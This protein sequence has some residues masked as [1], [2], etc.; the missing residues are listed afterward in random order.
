[1]FSHAVLTY[2]FVETPLHAGS[3]RGMGGID[4]PIQ[5]ERTTGYPLVQASGIKGKLRAEATSQATG[6]VDML[7]KVNAIFGPE[8]EPGKSPDH[9]GA[10][11]PG[12]ARLLL[13]PVRSLSG[14]FA[15]TTSANVLARF[16]RDL[17]AAGVKGV[18]WNVSDPGEGKALVAPGNDV[19]G[20]GKVVLEEFSY[21]PQTSNVVQQIGTW[22]AKN[23]LPHR[24]TQQGKVDE[25]AYWRT[26]LPKSLVV[27]PDADFRDFALYATE[28]VTRVRLENETKTVAGGAL[29]T[30][31]S[32]P[33]DTLMYTPIYAMNLRQG[34]NGKLNL[35]GKA[36]LE[37]VKQ[38]EPERI[39]LGGD[40]TVGRGLVALQF[41][42]VNNV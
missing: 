22:L 26:K 38:I 35:D 10:I 12:D 4:L 40:E 23:A 15:W 7:K 37:F 16:V 8:A 18:S 11:S 25:Y 33:V 19:T 39:Q 13:L 14:V 29:W 42:E 32:L 34:K 36:V 2:I 17:N 20:G 6:N 1:M 41:G 28:V 31:E 27:L 5:R 24:D 30:E 9:A 21:D 3:G